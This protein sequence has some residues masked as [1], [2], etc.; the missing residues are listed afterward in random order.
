MLLNYLGVISKSTQQFGY[1]G[2]Y[3]RKDQSILTTPL[4]A[5]NYVR[6]DLVSSMVHFVSQTPQLHA[7]AARKFY[8]ALLEENVIEHVSLQHT[9][10]IFNPYCLTQI[11]VE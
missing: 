10:I 11:T 4:Q 8:K 3:N 5:G 6:D 7:H 1:L 2:L 9:R